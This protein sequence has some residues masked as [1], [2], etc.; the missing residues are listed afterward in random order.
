MKP[1]VSPLGLGHI[2][3]VRFTDSSGD[4]VDIR[5]AI[6]VVYACA[7]DCIHAECTNTA[8]TRDERKRHGLIFAYVY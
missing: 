4:E 6:D 5:D 7:H 8:C 1:H 2:I 3:L